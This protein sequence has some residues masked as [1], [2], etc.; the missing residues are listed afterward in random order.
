MRELAAIIAAYLI[1]S[2]PSAYVWTRVKTGKDIRTMGSG[3]VGATNVFRS[4]GRKDGI[5][6]LAA[7]AAKGV[8]GVWIGIW[9]WG[10]SGGLEQY[11]SG[12]R[13]LIQF[14]L[15]CCAILGHVFTPWLKFKGGKGVATGAGVALAVYPIPLFLA[16]VCWSVILKTTRYMS[17]ASILAAYVFAVATAWIIPGKTH[18]IIALLAA[19]FITWTHRSNISRLR[20]GSESK[21]FHK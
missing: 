4:V 8:L 20:K 15:G 3:N 10:M 2:I 11:A 1:G 14:G 21:L 9:I 6:V 13:L 12:D 17:V 18:A 19:V 5:I 7:D 16:F